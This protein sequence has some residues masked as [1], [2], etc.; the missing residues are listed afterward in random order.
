MVR[1]KEEA[2]YRRGVRE[3]IRYKLTEFPATMQE[4]WIEGEL[5]S[6]CKGPFHLPVGVFLAR[7]N[8]QTCHWE[9]DSSCE[10]RQGDTI[11]D[12]ERHLGLHRSGL[13]AGRLASLSAGKTWFH[14]AKIRGKQ[15]V[16][17]GPSYS[18]T[19]G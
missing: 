13:S 8:N 12:V 7:R 14:E 11:F 15:G 5:L 1:R 9:I 19:P 4:E 10:V 17:P 18:G 6:I 2:A 3:G 16:D